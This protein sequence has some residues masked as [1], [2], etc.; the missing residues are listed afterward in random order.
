MRGP[1]TIPSS[2]ARFT[3]HMLGSEGPVLAIS[4]ACSSSAKVFASAHRAMRAGLCDAAV[5]GGVDSLC[6]M[7]LYGFNALQLVSPDPCRPADAR[8]NGISIGEAAGFALLEWP[9]HAGP[10]PQLLGYGATPGTS[11]SIVR[12]ARVVFWVIV[13]TAVFVRNS[14][15]KIRD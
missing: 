10:G 9:E 13:G 8:R 4:S 2:I 3:Q 1:A 15:M 5:V 7:T 12:K 14:A 6:L 11:L